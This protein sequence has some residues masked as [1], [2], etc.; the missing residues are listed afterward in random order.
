MKT[1]LTTLISLIS[2]TSLMAQGIHFEEGPWE[3]VVEKAKKADKVIYLDA[4]A[5]WCGPC[6]MMAKNIFPD[7]EVGNKYND[8][9]INYSVDAEKGEGID[10]ARKYKVSAYPTHLYINPHTE[11][12][13][14]F[15]RGATHAEGFMA[16]ADEAQKEYLDTLNL[17][18]YAKQYEEG[19]RDQEF[20]IAYIEKAAAKK[21]PVDQPLNAFLEYYVSEIPTKYWDFIL[22]HTTNFNSAPAKYIRNVAQEKEATWELSDF[23]KYHGW[24]QTAMSAT[25][26][27]AIGEQNITL[28]EETAESLAEINNPYFM[29]LPYDLNEL[30]YTQLKDEEALFN[31][32][33]H[34]LDYIA[35]KPIGF[36]QEYSIFQNDFIEKLVTAQFTVQMSQANMSQEEIQKNVEDYFQKNQLPNL[37]NLKLQEYINTT[38]KI[39]DEKR[40]AFYPHAI[41]WHEVALSLTDKVEEKNQINKQY[42]ALLILEGNIKQAQKES[43]KMYRSGALTLDT[44]D[45]TLD[46]IIQENI[47]L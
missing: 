14:T 37:I 44:T 27:Q 38:Q 15:Q 3:K 8:Y 23:L 10:L 40:N 13:V 12:I 11:E 29:V 18:Y 43:K 41:R 5:V 39:I 6:K 9:F 34:S 33:I 35:Q 25:L 30:Y 28:L 20:L 31:N 46:Q 24:Y 32:K 7:E 16:W 21:Q 47:Q 26:M 19:V 17:Q 4:Y 42:L 2:I 1:I 36:V 45:T 22:A